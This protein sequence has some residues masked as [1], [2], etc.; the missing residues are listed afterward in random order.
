MALFSIK[1]PD[2]YLLMRGTK[3]VDLCSLCRVSELGSWYVGAPYRGAGLLDTILKQSFC[4]ARTPVLV[5]GVRT[6]GVIAPYP[7]V[8]Q[9]AVPSLVALVSNDF[10]VVG[11]DPEDN[12]L[13]L[14]RFDN[15]HKTRLDRAFKL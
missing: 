4:L 3:I 5:S 12:G 2:Q 6:A 1:T 14:A 7:T 9:D 10:N 13:R 15:E 8:D 11:L